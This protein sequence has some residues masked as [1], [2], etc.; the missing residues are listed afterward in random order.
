MFEKENRYVTRGINEEVDIRIQI[1]LWNMIDKLKDK[2]DIKL[3]YLQ[4]FEV[5]KIHEIIKIE[6][7]QEVPNYSQAYMLNGMDIE[8]NSKI[9][10]FVIDDG[11]NSTMMLAE[12]Y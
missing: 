11:E 8:I 1:I 3:D 2:R 9:K 4:V 7:R 10:I 6:H 5:E 12:E